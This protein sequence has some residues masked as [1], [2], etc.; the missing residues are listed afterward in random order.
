MR[1]ASDLPP[2]N[3]FERLAT[4]SIRVQALTVNDRLL[5]VSGFNLVKC[6]RALRVPGLQTTVRRGIHRRMAEL[7]VDLPTLQALRGEERG[8]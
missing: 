2:V 5:M 8:R 1:R 6:L 7:G 4:A 3:P